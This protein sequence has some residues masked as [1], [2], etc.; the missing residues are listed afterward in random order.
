MEAFVAELQRASPLPVTGVAV[1]EEEF[2]DRDLSWLEF[3]SRVLNEALDP[4]TP[5]LERVRFLIIFSSNLDEFVMKRLA[6]FREEA[7]PGNVSLTAG[8][9]APQQ[10]LPRIRQVILELL[11]EQAE[12][13]SKTIR[14]LLAEQGIHLLDWNQ[15]DPAERQWAKGVFSNQHL[16]DPHA[17][18]G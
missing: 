10:L 14:P 1:S 6:A 2:L 7:R 9:I 13:L 16:S 4:R 18:G 3:N 5:L 11:W 17:A 12:C 15:L 8:V